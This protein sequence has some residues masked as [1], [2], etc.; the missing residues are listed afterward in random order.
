MS[1]AAE[2]ISRQS[3]AA[4][5]AL[6]RATRP[7]LLTLLDVLLLALFWLFFL[8]PILVAKDHLIPYDLIDQH[9]MFQAFIHRALAA[10]ESAWWSPDIL[11]GYPIVADP[12]TALFYP[13]NAAMHLLTR[14]DFLPYYRM[15]V[16]LALHLLWAAIGAYALARVLTGSRMGGLVAG[17][18]F[19][20][21]GFF[22]WHLPHLSPLSSLSWLPWVLFAYYLAV[23]RRSLVWVALGAVAF[24][25][26]VLAGHAMTILQ[27]GYLI[28][29]LAVVVAALSYRNDPS[30]A[31]WAFGSGIA[32]GL[33]G[34]GLAAIQLLPSWELSGETSRAG[35]LWAEASGSSFRPLWLLTAIVPDY[36]A[37][38]DAPLY[39]ATGDPAE[40]NI[41]LGLIPLFLAVLGIVSAGRHERRLV[42]GI[43]A[44]GAVALVLAFGSHGLIYRLVFEIAP[45][46]GHVR[47][48]GN[49]IA[50][51]GLAVA[52]LAA[53]GVRALEQRYSADGPRSARLFGRL[54]LAGGAL[55]LAGLAAA[56]LRRSGA[57]DP[58]WHERLRLIE[59][60]LLVAL[61][62][63]VVAFALV[64]ARVSLRLP[65]TALVGLLV[66]ATALDI[67][68]AN[69]NRVYPGFA[70][71]PDSYIGADW[72]A[73]PADPY[74]R[75]LLGL[76]REAAPDQF[77]IHPDQAGSTWI[78]GPLVWGLQSIDGYS[79]LWPRQYQEL[80]TLATG[81]PGSPVYDLLNI[82]YVLT[83]Q[84]LE[85]LYPGFDLSGFRLFQDG[86]MRVY[87][88]TD[89]IPRV[90][91]AQR[92][93]AQPPDDVI[94]W[95][96]A[97]AGS[98][99]DTV[100]VSDPPP[101]SISS[102]A[103]GGGQA[104][105]VS[106]ANDRVVVRASLPV[107]SYLVLADTYFPGWEATVDG[108]PARVQRADHALRAVWLPAGEHDV[109]FRYR[110]SQ[111]LTGTILT[112]L[113]ALAIAGLAAAPP[114]R[115]LRRRRAY[116]RL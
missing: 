18:V 59:R 8:W 20:F 104:A 39:W 111:R 72:A 49:F 92:W 46:F 53:F 70:H 71:R 41:Y 96:T 79:V 65:A 40:T 12:L 4:R 35:L 56:A 114:A 99:R 61:L 27:A 68:V 63:V 25:M 48:P 77:R 19:A 60:G 106:Y 10:G 93:V 24:G 50:V 14:G 87:E 44:A 115:R 22:V 42:G 91:I 32:I 78:N 108:R 86:W 62:L 69:R 116:G 76:Q 107:A 7:A 95:M 57:D 5:T 11:G 88:N 38:P 33:L 64:R 16:Q 90:W 73:A 31:A 105:I 37:P 83:T 23:T 26:L 47:R 30:R 80:F 9:Y 102:D 110:S 34:I 94:S 43:V 84:P 97:N 45:G 112:V 3:N 58:L 51:V 103:P 85:A 1:P 6:R 81:N 66:L 98:L 15:E 75:Q 52:L 21:G 89:A 13:P 67:G 74:V 36:F 55:L 2:A 54:L 29:T 109:E 17:L 100:V 82:R 28:G 101:G 113:S